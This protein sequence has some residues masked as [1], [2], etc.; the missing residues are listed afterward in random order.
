MAKIDLETMSD[1]IFL[2]Q[3]ERKEIEAL[4]NKKQNSAL[5]KLLHIH[6]TIID[7]SFGDA[8]RTS[9][10]YLR[11]VQNNMEKARDYISEDRFDEVVISPGDEFNQPK[12]ETM[13]HSVAV[14]YNKHNAVPERMTTMQRNLF[15]T[16][17]E[18]VNYFYLHRK[19]SSS[20]DQQ[21]MEDITKFRYADIAGKKRKR[22]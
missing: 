16:S 19:Y 7:A 2:S 15:D 1:A 22:T 17:E 18:L 12:I 3:E 10:Q 6:D 9:S 4:L 14:M 13:H 8:I 5:S 21:E 20:E 11:A